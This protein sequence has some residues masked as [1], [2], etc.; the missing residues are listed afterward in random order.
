[1]IIQL[2][3]TIPVNTSKGHAQAIMVI[4]YGTEHDLLWVCFLDSNGQCWT[5]KNQ[6]IRGEKNYTMGRRYESENNERAV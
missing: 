5:F 3:P 1:M 6:E 4:D 2:N